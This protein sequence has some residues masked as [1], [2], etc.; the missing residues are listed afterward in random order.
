MKKTNFLFFM[1]FATVLEMFLGCGDGGGGGGGGTS[2]QSSTIGGTIPGTPPAP[3]V[4]INGPGEF[5]PNTPTQFIASILNMTAPLTIE[6]KE[7]N[8]NSN[9]SF[10]ST[11][12]ASTE[13]SGSVSGE[14]ILIVE[15]TDSSREP[16]KVSDQKRVTI[17]PIVSPQNHPP[18][19][20][21][22]SPQMTINVG[23]EATISFT[24]S[25]EDHD[26]LFYQIK[27]ANGD[28][29]WSLGLEGI[30]TG[31]WDEMRD[32]GYSLGKSDAALAVV[33]KITFN[34]AKQFGPFQVIVMD[35][36]N[37]DA[38]GQFVVNVE[39]CV[40]TDLAHPGLA[41]IIGH[42]I[43]NTVVD[44]MAIDETRNKLYLL[45]G[46]DKILQIDFS[47]TMNGNKGKWCQLTVRTLIDDKGWKS[48]DG[49]QHDYPK[50]AFIGS[51][52]VGGISVDEK[53]DLY[54]STDII[55]SATKRDDGI[56]KLI[57]DSSKTAIEDTK[58]IAQ[59]LRNPYYSD[60]SSSYPPRACDGYQTV[61]IPNVQCAYKDQECFVYT[62]V[63]YR[64][65]ELLNPGSLWVNPSGNKLWA[66]SSLKWGWISQFSEDSADHSFL[67]VIA[68]GTYA[69]RHFSYCRQGWRNHNEALVRFG[70]IETG[71]V[72]SLAMHPDGH[73]FISSGNGGDSDPSRLQ[74]LNNI[75]NADMATIIA[76]GQ[77]LDPSNSQAVSLNTLL[78]SQNYEFIPAGIA[79]DSHQNLWMGDNTSKHGMKIRK[80]TLQRN[81]NSWTI[82]ENKEVVSQSNTVLKGLGK[83]DHPF[84]GAGV[85]RIS[86]DLIY[87]LENSE[88]ILG[89]GFIQP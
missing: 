29:L 33:H 24:V 20:E 81:S 50:L 9:I 78:E 40:E 88:V 74:V 30:A 64:E 5:S 84:S 32:R 41:T 47:F 53:G 23:T 66:V 48:K 1:L 34:V 71:S 57:L 15:V 17:T 10:N 18:V 79:F 7:G 14:Y 56:L 28:S 49:I 37:A 13:V 59:V 70:E 86:N 22:L 83:N 19:I 35:E 82:N 73:L 75:N 27:L 80:L 39:N 8:N 4:T 72:H 42:A 3:Q 67:G 31:T 46:F 62:D 12:Q 6:W 52:G 55:F 58:I 11:D 25:D 65:N 87:I 21:N 16:K 89:S 26:Q 45:A 68:A 36:H 63:P 76:Q 44:D 60:I 69:V 54:V 85:I 51:N 2:S 43:L 77:S 38:R 61:T